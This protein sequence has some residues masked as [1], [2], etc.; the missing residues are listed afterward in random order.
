MIETKETLKVNIN[1]S[2]SLNGTINASGSSYTLP[3]ASKDILGGIK[4]GENLTIDADGTLNAKAG[5]SGTSGDLSNLKYNYVVDGERLYVDGV[6][7]NDETGDGTESKPFK[8]LERFFDVANYIDGGRNDIRCYIVSAGVYTITKHSI[9]HLTIH[10]TG[11]VDGVILNFTTSRDVKFYE[12]HTNLNNLTIKYPNATE[13]AFDGG[14]VA[15]TKCTFEK[16][17][18]CYSCSGYFETVTMPNIIANYC[19]LSLHVINI[20]NTSPSVHAYRFESCVIRMYGSCQNVALSSTPTSSPAFIYANNSFIYCA[21]TLRIQNPTYKYGFYGDGNF[22]A[23]NST[24]YN[25]WTSRTSLGV[26]FKD[27]PTI[28][29]DTSS[30]VK[31]SELGSGSSGGGITQ[32]SD[33]TVPTWVKAITE[34]QITKWN[35]GTGDVDL[36]D[37]AKKNEIKTINGNSLIGEGNIVIEGGSGA[38]PEILVA[39]RTEEDYISISKA[40]GR[41][42]IYFGGI[43][44]KLGNNLTLT[45]DGSGRIVIG[46]G[47]SAVSIKGI[48]LFSSSL[49]VI[50]TTL[51][52][53]RNG[54]TKTIFTAYGEGTGTSTYHTLIN[55]CPLFFVQEGDIIEMAITSASVGDI[56]VIKGGTSLTVQKVM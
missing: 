55:E 48:L 36:T 50:E 20:T 2:Q 16:A 56:N 22:V 44:A 32:E 13:F 43:G 26:G 30:N 10:I 28:F 27:V 3:I 52:Y 54:T 11:N 31:I 47:I 33:P 49:E 45:S 53:T 15:L 51:R 9:N 12:C 17:V 19:N 39:K 40:W 38:S 7:G 41:Q 24:Y 34:E 37:Y 23:T 4:V 42:A 14:S 1:T 29:S 5:G 6:N 21:I 25:Y 18:T 35:S 46:S 8:T